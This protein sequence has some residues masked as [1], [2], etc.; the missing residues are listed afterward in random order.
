M[1]DIDIVLHTT[2][3][4]R[5]RP[6]RGA[7]MLFIQHCNL[8]RLTHRICAR[9]LNYTR[10]EAVHCCRRRATMCN[11]GTPPFAAPFCEVVSR[12]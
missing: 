2:T 3:S 8:K 7:I 11:I 9:W 5:G 4:N 6:A 10:T 12:T 1:A